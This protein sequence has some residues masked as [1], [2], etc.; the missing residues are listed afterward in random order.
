MLRQL[1][2]KKCRVT[3]QVSGVRGEYCLLKPSPEIASLDASKIFLISM[4]S[5]I[6]AMGFYAK[7]FKARWTA[8]LSEPIYSMNL[9]MYHVFKDDEEAFFHA[10]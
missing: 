7:D 4:Y 10:M 5:H 3:K 8:F 2:E 9:H 6:L 1:F